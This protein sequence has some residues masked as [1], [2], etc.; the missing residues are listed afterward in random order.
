LPKCV[1][2][3]TIYLHAI[4]I[5]LRNF[6]PIFVHLFM[7]SF[8]DSSNN[9]FVLGQ[10]VWYPPHKSRLIMNPLCDCKL[11]HLYGIRLLQVCKLMPGSCAI[12]PFCTELPSLCGLQYCRLLLREQ[13]YMSS[14]VTAVLSSFLQSMI[15]DNM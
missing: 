5:V 14:H 4:I 7:I 3:F 1:T 10:Y 9:L 12:F 2:I 8:V 6:N 11:S 15:S 13:K